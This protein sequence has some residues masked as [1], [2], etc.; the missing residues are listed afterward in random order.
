MTSPIDL[1]SDTVTRP[2]KA[3]RQA[4]MDAET[5]MEAWV[6]ST[7]R[8]RQI[9]DGA[10][11]LYQTFNDEHSQFARTVWAAYNACTETSDWR[12]GRGDVDH[13]VVFGPRA[14]EKVR[15]FKAAL[16]L[17]TGASLN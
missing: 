12:E 17:T 1:R 14:Q 8:V 4:I 10:R 11:V 13:S 9:R 3:M 6:T 7:D 15:A 16:E 5:A 2:G